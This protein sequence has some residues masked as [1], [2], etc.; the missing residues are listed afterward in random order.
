[1]SILMECQKWDMLSTKALGEMVMAMEGV[2]EGATAQDIRS[3]L[4][5]DTTNS[6]LHQDLSQLVRRVIV[7]MQSAGSENEQK[8]LVAMRDVLTRM[9]GETKGVLCDIDSIKRSLL[10]SLARPVRSPPASVVTATK[11]NPV[12]IAAKVNPVVIAAKVNPVVPATVTNVG[13]GNSGS[14]GNNMGNVGTVSSVS[15]AGNV[16]SV[17]NAGNASTVSNMG[18]VSVASNV[19]NVSNVGTITI[20]PNTT[21]TTNIPILPNTT[22]IPN[23]TNTTNIPNTTNTPNM[24]YMSYVTNLGNR[25]NRTDADVISTTYAYL[26]SYVAQ[27]PQNANLYHSAYP[28]MLLQQRR[29]AQKE[30]PVDE[31]A[32]TGRGTL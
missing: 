26:P 24:T 19:G 16:G 25:I 20:L 3:V 13:N 30:D 15:N 18:S 5:L 10:P 2:Q 9:L 6:R 29:T 12:V 14:S 4:E 31:I 21:N 8:K 23:T 17:G 7:A 27:N 22:I 11:V 1:M 32:G 28:F